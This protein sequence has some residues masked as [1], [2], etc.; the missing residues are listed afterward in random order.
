MLSTKECR[1]K[2]ARHSHGIEQSTI[3]IIIRG[4]GLKFPDCHMEQ[5]L[6]LEYIS[7]AANNGRKSDGVQANFST[8]GRHVSVSAAQE[9]R[10]ASSNN[11]RIAQPAQDRQLARDRNF[12]GLLVPAG[13]EA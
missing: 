13:Q 4:Q 1:P 5:Q 8:M 7:G 3:I 12:L 6:R 2:S 10:Q 9:N 11:M